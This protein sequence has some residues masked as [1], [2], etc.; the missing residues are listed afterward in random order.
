MDREGPTAHATS[1][2]AV[3]M[4]AEFAQK[5]PV[6]RLAAVEYVQNALFY[7]SPRA[8]ATLNPMKF[9][10]NHLPAAGESSNMAT[11]ADSIAAPQ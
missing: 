10:L 4:P 9:G 6:F 8:P 1:M 3:G 11:L 5:W 7:G 2:G